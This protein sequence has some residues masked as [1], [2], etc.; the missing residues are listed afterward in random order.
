MTTIGIEERA[1]IREGF[2]RLLSE[3]A[4][5]ADLRRTMA[6]DSG[7]DTDLWKAISDMGIAGLLV[8]PDHGGVGGSILDVETIMEEA[9]AALLA[10]PLLSGGV[11]AVALLAESSDADL[12]ARLLP[13]IASG[14]TI[15]TVAVTGDNGLWTR[16]DI[17]VVATAG[18]LSGTASYVLSANIADVLLVVAIAGDGVAVF[19]VDSKAGGVT[20]EPLQAW[21]PTLRLSRIR[22]D[23]VAAK[24]L[25]GVDSSSVERTLDLAR[26]ALAGEQAGAARRIFDITVEY[27]RTRVQFGRPIGGF[28]ALKHM[29]ADLLVEV[30]SATS[31]ARA[32]AQALAKGTPD[33]AALVSLAAFACADAFHQVAAAAIQMHGGIAFTWEHPAH[34]YLRRA[35]VDAQLFGA[36]AYHRDRYVSALETAA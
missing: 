27:L 21:D 26:V 18:W 14:E 10:A 20:I 4:S 36:S 8:D 35:R 30:E 6:S 23:K 17:G 13:A 15:A 22:F 9:G 11:M 24:V 28:Q 19:E 25:A 5:E 33:A 16:D 1:A 34:L 7:H 32:A 29:A 3:K 12:K 31:A 2:A